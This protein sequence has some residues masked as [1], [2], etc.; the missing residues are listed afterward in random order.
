MSDNEELAT[1]FRLRCEDLNGSGHVF[2]IDLGIVQ[3][4]LGDLD[5]ANI[6]FRADAQ[7]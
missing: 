5:V 6:V 3:A 2:R 4:P 7:E 1:C